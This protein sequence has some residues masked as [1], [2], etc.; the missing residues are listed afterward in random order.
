MRMNS[1]L[2]GAP[3]KARRLG[4]ALALAVGVLGA[5]AA[6]AAARPAITVTPASNL[7]PAATNSVAVAGTGFTTDALPVGAAGVYV[8]VTA[9]VGGAI[10]A[11][12]ARARFFINAAI[13]TGAFNAT[14][15][16]E[17]RFTATGG[18]EVDCLATQCVVR[19][20]PAHGD[21]TAGNTLATR[22]ITF[23]VPTSAAEV[24]VTPKNDIPREG[25]T[26]LT[27]TG[28]GF[29]PNV[30]DANGFYVA[31]GPKIAEYWRSDT[32]TLGAFKW[33]QPGAAPTAA[34]DTL[35]PDGTFS[36]TLTIT[37]AYTRGATTYD[38]RVTECAIFTFAAHGSADRSADTLTPLTFAP[39]PPKVEVTPTSGLSG[40]GPTTVT[41]RGSDFSSGT[42]VSQA[43]IINGQ[44]VTP[45]QGS[46]KWIRR[47]APTPDQALN[48][49]GTFTT[50]LTV[51]P[52]FPI[53]G[54]QTVDCRVTQ[55][56]IVTWRQHSNPTVAALYTNT[57]L[58]FNAATQPAPDASVT[59]VKVQTLGKKRV[60]RIGFVTCKADC[61]IS[62]PKT[63]KVKIGKK[64][65]K[66]TV[67]APK[68]AKA[69]K[70]FQVRVKL[71]KA[72][73]KALA[74]RRAKVAVNVKLTANGQSETKKLSATIKAKKA[75]KS[76][77]KATG[78]R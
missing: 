7:D 63:V 53:G 68:S 39:V 56:A 64:K 13:P 46:A 71:T 58:A 20:W 66:V 38:C 52:T 40:D 55:C 43:A 21:P 69:G 77:K 54:G 72:A 5:G 47:G 51:T 59:K 2:A 62:T 17:R 4:T 18:A 78:K 57:P 26:T 22:A 31:Y 29:D 65:Y 60:A 1:R 75:K 30:A 49:D 23:A 10:V 44:V 36:T 33:I 32:A 48:A 41:I 11:D 70:R 37:P 61:A 16:V 73:A 27:I 3:R 8:A 76:T 45:D 50:T 74:G 14:L 42:Y 19:T 24:T 35:N 34:R 15:D 67:L 28:R 6:T 9:D 25:E 12:N